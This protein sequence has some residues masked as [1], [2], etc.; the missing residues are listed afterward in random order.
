V[1][2]DGDSGQL[3][4]ARRRPFFYRNL[5][6]IRLDMAS[7]DDVMRDVVALMGPGS[8]GVGGARRPAATETA[9]RSAW[10]P[11]KQLDELRVGDFAL[12]PVWINCHVDDYDEPWYEQTDEE[13]FRPWT[14]ALPV[15]PSQGTFLVRAPA[16]SRDGA[17]YSGFLT[18]AFEPDFG[19]LRP[20]IFI[21]DRPWGFWGG[22]PGVQVGWRQQFYEAARKEPDELFPLSV[23][24]NGGL[25]SGVTSCEVDGFCWL[26]GASV[27]VER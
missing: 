18:P 15:S 23:A 8:P 7:L 22:M 5:V 13:T 4:L 1:R 12:H 16:R 26:Q 6:H 19:A 17:M 25:A 20:D 3:V 27:V 11:L 2:F 14:G 24:C 9:S 21:G 10:P